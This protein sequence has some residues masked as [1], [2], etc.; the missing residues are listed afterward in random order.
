MN[1]NVY[2]NE[3]ASD[4]AYL[5]FGGGARKCV[6]DEF[7]T[8]WNVE[9]SLTLAM[10]LVLR[11]FEFEFDSAKL[12]ETKVDIWNLEH[13]ED[14]DHAVGMRTGALIHTMKELKRLRKKQ[15][16]LLALA[17]STSISQLPLANLSNAMQWWLRKIK[18]AR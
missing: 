12:A 3:V 14:L 2:P 7:A 4:F 11:R 16:G 8:L 6:D 13:P 1:T 9:A 10:V 15:D 18:T 17:S 5:P